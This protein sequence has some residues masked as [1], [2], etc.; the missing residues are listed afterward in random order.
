MPYFVDCEARPNNVVSDFRVNPTTANATC[1]LACQIA[2]RE[3]GRDR[4]Y[5]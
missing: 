5:R 4:D 2:T 3:A 1:D